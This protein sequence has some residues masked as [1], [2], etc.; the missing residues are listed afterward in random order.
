[1]KATYRV[2][3][4]EGPPTYFFPDLGTAK[5]DSWTSSADSPGEYVI[6]VTAPIAEHAKMPIGSR[7][8]TQVDIDLAIAA[9]KAAA[10][11]I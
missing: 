3:K 2:A 8:Q 11:E 9:V 1:M 4:V 5:P 10:K 7:L 6:T